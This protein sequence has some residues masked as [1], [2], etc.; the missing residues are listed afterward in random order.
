MR[1]AGVG[2]EETAERAIARAFV[3][4]PSVLLFDEPLSNLD[5]KLRVELRSEILCLQQG[6]GITALYVNHDQEE[7][8]T[9]ADQL[10][11]EQLYRLP[12]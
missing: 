9:I 5:A 12:R 6:L 10:V 11:P 1:N 4:T 7:A 2:K 8:M 3:R